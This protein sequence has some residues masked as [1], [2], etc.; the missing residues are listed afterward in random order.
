M[1]TEIPEP[2]L[3]KARKM[4]VVFNGPKGWQRLTSLQRF[5]LLKLT[6]GGH[7]NA[8]FV[9]ALREFGLTR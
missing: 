2:I 9:P 7:E 5:T 8:N 4:G 3:A 1:S 6:R